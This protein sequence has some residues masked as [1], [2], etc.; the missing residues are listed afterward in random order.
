MI[1][2]GISSVSSAV[3]VPH[4]LR[5]RQAVQRAVAQL[6][7][8]LA[9]KEMQLGQAAFIRVFKQEEE[10]E[11]W[12]EKD[13]QMELFKTWPIA[14]FSGHPGPK[15]K[16]GDNQAPEGF[17]FV[18]PNQ[19]NPHSSYHLS[20]NLGYP[21]RYDRTHGYTGN[22]LMVHGNSVSIGC[23]AMTDPVIEEIWTLM[24]AAYRQGQPFIRVHIFPFRMTPDNMD[25]HGGGPWHEFWKNLQ[26]GY[27]S[28][29]STGKVPNVEV[30]NSRYV[31][32]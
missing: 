28:F 25:R 14:K 4:S 26:E 18:P 7:P 12:L 2:L 31:F 23:Y 27:L 11:L 1:L 3:E 32:E 30:K 19:L 21:N 5:S 9:A 8:Q 20:F 29:E 17:Y 15:T 6:E 10:L 22:Y 24:D 13:G 16:Q